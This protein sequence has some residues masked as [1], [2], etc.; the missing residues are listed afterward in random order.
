[1][2]PLTTQQLHNQPESNKNNKRNIKQACKPLLIPLTP[3]NSSTKF[4][5]ITVTKALITS[6]IR[7]S[8]Y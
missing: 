5:T 4:K 1:M 8:S 7:L 2:T 3:D 6:L